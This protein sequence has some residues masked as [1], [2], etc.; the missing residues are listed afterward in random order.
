MDASARHLRVLTETIAAVNSTLD[1]QEVL[2]L[3]ASKVAEA[4]EAD[5][6]F[7]Y[8]YDDQADELVLRATHGTRVE[9]MTRTPR[10]K[11]GEGPSRPPVQGLSEPAGGPVRVDP[12]GPDPG[13]GEARGGSERADDRAA[14]VLRGGDGSPRGHC[15]PGRADDR[16]R[17]ALRRRAG[18][19]FRAGGAVEDLGGRLRVALPR[20]VARGN[21]ED[22]DGGGWRDRRCARPRGRAQRR[23]RRP[24][25]SSSSRLPLAT[26]RGRATRR[27]PPRSST[28]PPARKRAPARRRRAS[29]ARSSARPGQQWPRGDPSPP[30]RTRAARSSARSEPPRASPVPGSGPRGSTRTG[31]PAGSERP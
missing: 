7:V 1:L 13:T 21:R 2:G 3:V 24:P 10:M 30:R 20:G 28:A 31:P 12:R 27:R 18:A 8:L 15:C 6:C 17:E 14:R 22:D 9:E 5:A 11:P 4:L 23:S 19:R 25:P 16:A 26:P 29:R